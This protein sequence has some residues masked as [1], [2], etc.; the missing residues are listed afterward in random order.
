MLSL[1]FLP[2]E[3]VAIA[4]NELGDDMQLHP[5]AG[6][7]R[8][9]SV[10]EQAL[11][12][13]EGQNYR[14][15]SCKGNQDGLYIRVNPVKRG[16][17]KNEDVTVFRH[18]LV[19]FD[20]D[21]S[22]AVIPKEVQFGILTRS[23][24]PITTITD[25]ANKSLHAWVRVDARDATEYKERAEQV[26]AMFAEYG[27]DKAN[28]NPSRLSRCP[29][30]L[31]DINGDIRVQHLLATQLGPK[32]WAEY[33]AQQQVAMVGDAVSI[34]EL[35]EYDV[36]NDP[37]SVLGK[38]WLCKGGTV[39]FVG[40]AGTGKS[41]LNM[42]LSIG[43]ALNEPTISFGINAGRPLK[44]LIIQAENDRGDMAEMVQGVVKALGLTAKDIAAL[45]ENLI[46][47]RDA[48]H[49]GD[50]FLAVL[51]SL[52]RIHKPDVAWIDPL[53]NYI[54]DDISEQR[55]CTGFTNKMNAIGIE[56]GCILSVVHH[57]G[58]PKT[59]AAR[60]TSD[61]AYSG[62]GS[63]VLTNWAREVVSLARIPAPDGWPRTFELTMTKR[64]YRAGLKR[65]DATPTDRITICH[66]PK[67]DGGICWLQ[68]PAPPAPEAEEKPKGGWKKQGSN[69]STKK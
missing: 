4:Q 16:G 45:S 41:S 27:V 10:W 17:S 42:Q 68:C 38:R 1:A 36:E 33:Q 14:V 24:L 8:T 49:S 5:T 40:Q 22:G 31:R 18:L 44:I 34:S 6:I 28:K 60:T 53:L 32:N 59:D 9:R 29:G 37:N 20:K 51:E 19:E 56:T 39:M 62:L 63:S 43:W 2:D 25:S 30:G 15:I 13:K 50:E 58:K 69:Y 46:I 47:Y 11:R 52:I 55:V 48:T 7:A 66:N 57:T 35:I 3:F 65:L 21:L 67:R 26:Y 61:L 12:E 23:G 64:G 54:G